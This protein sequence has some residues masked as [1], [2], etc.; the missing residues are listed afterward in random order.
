M[1]VGKVLRVSV[2]VVIV[3]VICGMILLYFNSSNK[4][5]NDSADGLFEASATILAFVSLGSI[6]GIRLSSD[7][8]QGTAQFGAVAFVL[9]LSIVVLVIQ[10]III[11]SLCCFT[12]YANVYA[13]LMAVT[14]ICFIAAFIG[15]LAYVYAQMYRESSEDK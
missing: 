12:L 6:L 15:C 9:I 4:P 8:T 1:A 5:L 11:I 10:T 13:V 3:L 7:K 14:A 2:L